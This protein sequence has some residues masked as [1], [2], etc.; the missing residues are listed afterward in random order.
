MWPALKRLENYHGP[1]DKEH[2]GVDGPIHV[3]DGT[4]RMKRSEADF[5]QAFERVGFKEVKDVNKL[6]NAMGV[7]KWLRYIDQEGKR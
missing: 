5:I 6:D 1:G 2:H 4:Y 7:Q 3:G